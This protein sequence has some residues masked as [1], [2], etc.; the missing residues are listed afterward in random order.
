[1]NL[2]LSCSIASHCSDN[3][4]LIL[5]ALWHP[6]ISMLPKSSTF[7]YTRAKHII[8]SLPIERCTCIHGV[9]FNLN[10]WRRRC[11]R[12]ILCWADYWLLMLIFKQ[13]RQLSNQML[14]CS[15]ALWDHDV[16]T[17]SLVTTKALCWNY[18]GMDWVKKKLKTKI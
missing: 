18:A 4:A 10:V 3:T 6:T 15:C 12:I 2:N 7:T 16:V 13:G 8:Y 11:V 1:M 17:V 14:F 5:L 9:V